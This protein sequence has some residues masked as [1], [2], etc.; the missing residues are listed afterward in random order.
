MLG[1]EFALR[2][3]AMVREV[4][5]DQLDVGLSDVSVGLPPRKPGQSPQR[6]LRWA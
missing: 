6:P 1:R 2:A 5:R 4:I 3:R